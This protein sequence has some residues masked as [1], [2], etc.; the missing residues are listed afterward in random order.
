MMAYLANLARRGAG[1]AP[2]LAPR[3]PAVAEPLGEALTEPAPELTAHIPARRNEDQKRQPCDE[4]ANG[5][6]CLLHCSLY[7]R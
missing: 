5:P 3:R 7:F 4:Q 2:E 6:V 1:L